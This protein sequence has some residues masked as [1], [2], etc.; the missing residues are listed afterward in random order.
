MK[1]QSFLKSIP[2]FLLLFFGGEYAF[3]QGSWHKTYEEPSLAA[4]HLYVGGSGGVALSKI[5]FKPSVRQRMPMGLVA[6]V[7]ASVENATYT[8]VQLEL[9]YTQRGWREYYTG[10]RSDLSF[11]RRLHFVNLPLLCHLYYP[12]G[13]FRVG[14]RVGP[15]MSWVIAESSIAQG[16]GFLEYEKER[17]NKPLAHR[18][19]WGVSAGPALSF[20]WGKQRLELEG[21][22]Y[23]GLNDLFL[24][25]IQDA[26]SNANELS[27]LGKVNYLFRVL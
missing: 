13:S 11:L 4:P 19:T 22:F 21:R 7:V 25:S 17:H 12:L 1:T 20:S 24:T 23:Y 14:V 6:G 5:I 26:Y 10:S 16:D 3:A 15:Q 9:N 8:G 18:F 27:I 2:I